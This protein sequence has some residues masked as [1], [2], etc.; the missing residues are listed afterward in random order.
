MAKYRILSLDGGG[1]RGLITSRFLQRL[2]DDPT[3]GGWLDHVDL[4]VGTSTGGLLALALA[5]GKNPNEICDLYL[6]SGGKIFNDS[7]WDDVRDLGKLVGADY[8]NRTLKRELKS[9]FGNTVLSQLEKKVAIPAFDLDNEAVDKAKRCWKPKIF[10]NFSGSDS[11]GA[12]KAADVALYTS[13]APTYFPSADGYIDGGVYA[14][15]PSMVAIAQAISSRNTQSERA[16]LNDIVMLS[17]GTGASVNFIKG[18][19]LDWGYG[20]W[21]KPLIEVVMDGVAGIADYQS[22]Q[23]LGEKY[24]RL[25]IIFGDNES[26]KLDDVKKL[27]RMDELAQNYDLS[28]INQWL[29]DHWL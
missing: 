3:N 21:I 24:Q 12:M 22:S 14:N 19:T 15:N 16:N 10:H 1:L 27:P 20:Q 26:I 6:N 23:L 25:Q 18:K 29:A 28:E 11:D 17:V 13:S 4:I 2:S 9:I 8:S 7:I 5:H